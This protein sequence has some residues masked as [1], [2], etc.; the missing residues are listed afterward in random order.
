MLNVTK[1]FLPELSEYT[2]YL[3]RIW[4]NGIITNEGPFVKELQQK[5]SLF[6]GVKHAIYV[7]NGT[8]ALQLALQALNLKGKIITTP[9]SYCATANAIIWEKCEPIF[10]DINP[11]SLT[12]EVEN[13][14]AVFTDE[15]TAILT[16]HV[17]GNAVQL[18]KI[19]AF[20][21]EKN[22]PVIFDAAHCFG[23][24]YDQK[25]IFNYGLFSTCSFHATKIF[26]TIEGGAV[27][28][29]DDDLAEKIQLLKSFGHRGDEYYIAGI[30]G[31][32][33]EMNAAMGLINLTHFEKIKAHR[34]WA[35]ERYQENLHSLDG[36]KLYHWG[37]KIGKNYSYFPI[38]FETEDKLLEVINNLNQES[39]FPRRY[40]YP[41][42]NTLP[43]VTYQSCPTAEEI[44]KKT[45]CLPLSA[46]ITVEEIEKVCSIIKLS[47]N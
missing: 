6:T 24:D 46:E 47:L 26:H 43:F 29:N 21:N 31:K 1:T 42:L 35:T 11:E 27:F 2:S 16:T 13:L 32:T 18:E 17:Y 34:K 10:A 37:E 22:I 23:V 19:E 15:V 4:S 45:L 3:E 8:I 12:C 25:S 38:I 9:F 5:L 33:S 41:A 7:S 36:I 30:N 20:A 28:T 40:F 39:I 44:S 14:K